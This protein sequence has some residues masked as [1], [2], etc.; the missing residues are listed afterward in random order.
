MASGS[1]DRAP[2]SASDPS[3]AERRAAPHLELAGL[4]FGRGQSDTAL[5]EIKKAL[6]AKPD[7]AAAFGLRGLIQASLGEP[8]LAE[9]SFQR[10]LQLAPRDGDVMHNYGWFLCQQRRYG[11][12]VA[13]FLAA[14]AEPPYREVLRTQLA[15]GVCEA[16]AGRWPEA[17]KA[18]TR[19]YELDPANPVTAYNLSEVL[20]RRGELERAR[21]Y[22][23]R[24]NAVRDL[25]TA[26]SLWLAV[27]IERQL[28]NSQA[29]QE[30]GRQLR[31]RFP[32]AS[33]A[34]Q[35]ERGRFDE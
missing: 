18:L 13:Q 8:R 5:D 2:R 27:R 26:Q 34:L 23:G 10:A 25:A 4:Y 11:E 19:A 20:L 12:A 35:F 24:I 29:V 31:E 21:F 22:V 17:E 16:R 32:Q 7:I 9:E 30:L 28:G 3:D 14:L 1:G 6:A 15:L 33:E